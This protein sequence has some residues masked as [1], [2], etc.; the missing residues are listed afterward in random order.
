[1]RL[2][3]WK[4]VLLSLSLPLVIAAIIALYAL[5]NLGSIYNRIE[6]IEAADDINLALLE[7]RRYERNVLL[8]REEE[9]SIP[10]FRGALDDLG[11]RIHRIEN[12]ILREINR[13]NYQLLTESITKYREHAET[14]IGAVTLGQDLLEEIRPLGREIEKRS[15]Q[16][17][18]ALELRRHEK[19][20]LI[21]E[22]K[23][24]I[25]KL[26]SVAGRLLAIQPAMKAP[27]EN[28]LGVIDQIVSSVE[29]KNETVAGLRRYG[30]EIEEITLEFSEKERLDIDTTLAQ[31]KRL[32]I[33]SFVLL[34]LSIAVISYRFSAN[35]VRILK[36]VE[37]SLTRR[38][39]F[40]DF[41][42]GIDIQ[43]DKAPRE[44]VSFVDAYNHAVETLGASKA[45]LERTMTQI[46]EVNRE[47]LEKQ[48]EL[49]EARKLAALRLLAGEIA[50]EVNNPLSTMTTLLHLLAEEM[51]AKDSRREPLELVIEESKRCRSIVADLAD[52][53]RREPLKLK[54]VNPA[55]LILEA[56]E[57]VR[58]Q[59]GRGPKR[60]HVT[61]SLNGAVPRL[62]ADPILL[63]QALINVI[64]NAW[65][66][67]PDGGHVEVRGTVKDRSLMIEVEDKGCGIPGEAIPRIFDPF[68]STRKDAGG[69]G[70]G[71][72]ITRKIVERH[73]GEITVESGEGSGALFRIILP[74][75]DGACDG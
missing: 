43:R 44:I 29:L 16:K 51:P 5:L 62:A 17:P 9:N 12:E 14:L 56:I 73:G 70:L 18:L 8:F 75:S 59:Q 65:E 1:M 10:R 22:E 60:V 24:S 41:S 45:E 13:K 33:A 53:A 64:S 32:F 63:R 57:S 6:H 61:S 19:N 42:H 69:S 3:L 23:D 52:F 15:S 67:S 28:Y 71:L 54:E 26:R 40:G 2:D 66:F 48:E 68:F 30:S 46:E 36:A 55:I 25:G 34:L 4:Q 37:D 50:H 31:A 47:L 11:K 72:A 35:V 38:L 39:K 21:Y 58:S 27:L 20:F 49:V 74:L 7:L